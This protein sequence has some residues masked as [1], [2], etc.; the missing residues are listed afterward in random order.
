MT[1][2]SV[3]AAVVRGFPLLAALTLLELGGG[4]VLDGASATLLSSPSLLVL[5]PVAIG[6][7]GNLGSVLAARLST[8]LHLGTLSFSVA[9]PRLVGNAAGAG[10]LAVTTFPVVGAGAWAVAAVTTGTRLSAVTVVVVAT[11]SGL[12]LAVL[13]I[14][15]T[16]VVTYAAYRVGADPDEVV[17]PV[18][19]NVADVLG[20]VV[21]LGVVR[22]LT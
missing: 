10:A 15:V 7:A 4:L 20:V 14:G 17:V 5:V 13:A 22:L 1:R 21:L 16:V 3:R 18:V 19:T 9:D 2:E 12:V 8:A 11:A 6:A